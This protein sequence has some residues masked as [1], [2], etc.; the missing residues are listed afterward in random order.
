M[1]NF[2]GKI[3]IPSFDYKKTSDH[4]KKRAIG[5]KERVEYLASK[6]LSVK[7]KWVEVALELRLTMDLHI[8]L[9]SL[10]HLAIILLAQLRENALVLPCLRNSFKSHQFISNLK[11]WHLQDLKPPTQ[12]CICSI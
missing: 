1:N 11:I 10:E 4:G 9:D 6:M 2:K 12:Q 3:P 8:D 7:M 5:L